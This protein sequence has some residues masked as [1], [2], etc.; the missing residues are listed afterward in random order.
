MRRRYLAV[1]AAPGGCTKYW[2]KIKYDVVWFCSFFKCVYLYFSPNTFPKI[3]KKTL[4]QLEI[5]IAA[6]LL[7]LGFKDQVSALRLGNRVSSKSE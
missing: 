7:T 3:W 6:F 2:N 4:G 1:D 5:H